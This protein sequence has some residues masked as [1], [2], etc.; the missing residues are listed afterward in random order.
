MPYRLLADAVLA[1]HVAIVVFVVA[2]LVFVLW[3]NR[4]GWQWVNRPGFRI[5]HVAAIAIVVAESWLGLV[6][7]LTTFEMWLRASAGAPA[8]SGSFI[9]HWLQRLLYYDA[10]P[11]VFILGY[12]AFGCWCC[13]PGGAIRRRG[14][15]A[16][17][18][19]APARCARE[20]VP[21]RNPLPSLMREQFDMRLALTLLALVAAL[22]GAACAAV[23]LLQRSMIYYPQPATGAGA[24]RM[25]LAVDGAEI[26]VAVRPRPATGAVLYFGG[27]AEDVSRSLPELA[28]ALP[29]RA[30][31]AMHYR[32]YGG[33]TGRPSEHALQQDALAVF[34]KI[35]ERH[36]D[37]MVIGRSLGSGIA[38]RLASL[39][40]VSRLV[41][42]TPF[43]SLASLAAPLFPWLPIRW[44][45]L[46][47]YDSAG[48]APAVRAPTLVLAAE[49]DEIVPRWSTQ[50]LLEQFAPGIAAMTII[51]GTGHNTISASPAYSAA[52]RRF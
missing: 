3:G 22:Y 39:R 46:D 17:R 44:L 25:K 43:D 7:P 5:A 2:G 27:N 19:R 4:A 18:P 41:L 21:A 30:I 45:L 12:S 42:V 20:Q 32:G 40:P 6:C 52:L 34:D 28:E 31:Y 50:R 13:W 47:R 51:P 8:Y 48:L 14:V 26:V 24:E 33:S 1:L 16:P 49:Q 10:P 36:Q 29:Q 38:V 23:L 11:W 37:V 15:R 35:V 9:E